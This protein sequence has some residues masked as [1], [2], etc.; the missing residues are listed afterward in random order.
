MEYIQHISKSFVRLIYY[1]VDRMFSKRPV[2]LT[3]RGLSS[4][5]SLFCFKWVLPLKFSDD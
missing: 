1:C 4:A 5:F 2:A 3:G